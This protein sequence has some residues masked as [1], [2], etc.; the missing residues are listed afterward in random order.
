MAKLPAVAALCEGGG[1]IG[2]FDNTVLTV[3]QGKGGVCHPPTMFSGDLHHNRAGTLP[4]RPRLV[5]WVEVAGSFDYEALGVVDGSGEGGGE[6]GVVIRHGIHRE[7][8]NGELEVSG[9]ESESLPGVVGDGEGLIEAGGERLKKG[10]IGGGGDGGVD[11]GEGDG[12]FTV[13]KGLE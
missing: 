5:V 3:E 8:V 13:D 10:S 4:D 6:E 2:P 7:A 9:G 1:G 11:N 12:A